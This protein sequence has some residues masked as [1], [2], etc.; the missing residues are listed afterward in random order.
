MLALRKLRAQ[1]A[2]SLLVFV[3]VFSAVSLPLSNGIYLA[4]GETRESLRAVSP[5][6]T[7]HVVLGQ[8]FVHSGG[9][10][11]TILSSFEEYTG[12]KDPVWVRQALMSTRELLQGLPLAVDSAEDVETIIGRPLTKEQ[13][14][15]FETGGLLVADGPT[16]SLG[17][18]DMLPTATPSG[19]NTGDLRVTLLDGVP[20]G[21]RSG[22]LGYVS[23]AAA[24]KA[25][26]T[27]NNGYAIYTNVH[28]P[29]L[30]SAVRAPEE[31]SFDRSAVEVYREVRPQQLPLS[32]RVMNGG[33][34]VLVALL[35]LLVSLRHVRESRAFAKTL[36]TVGMKSRAASGVVL[37]MMA[38]NVLLPIVLGHAA[39]V[40]FSV[41][42]F[43]SLLN[44]KLGATIPWDDVWLSLGLGLLFVSATVAVT[45]SIAYRKAGHSAKVL[46]E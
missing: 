11:P 26:W 38:V 45:M 33:M 43:N 4:T 35:A 13:R 19:K 17:N 20:E 5:V 12:L 15:A 6:P 41:I 29:A 24:K 18:G 22:L 30:E 28:G 39:A 1:G 21:Y 44:D 2:A 34:L 36:E 7:G 27:L 8:N 10:S 32:M 40:I 46:T 23:T 9:I 3:A 31:K 16:N 42:A 37:V 14:A 25:G